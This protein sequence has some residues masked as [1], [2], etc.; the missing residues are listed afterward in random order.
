MLEGTTVYDVD[1]FSVESESEHPQPPSK[2]TH[3]YSRMTRIQMAV[4]IIGTMIFASAIVGAVLLIRGTNKPKPEPGTYPETYQLP[5]RVVAIEPKNEKIGL[6]TLATVISD[7]ISIQLQDVQTDYDNAVTDASSSGFTVH[8]ESTYPIDRSSYYLCQLRRTGY[9]QRLVTMRDDNQIG[10]FNQVQYRIQLNR[11][12]CD[13]TA[14]ADEIREWSVELKIVDNLV[15]RVAIWSPNESGNYLRLSVDIL[16]DQNDEYPM[17]KMTMSWELYIPS[18]GK[19]MEQGTVWT[20]RST[21]NGTYITRAIVMQYINDGAFYEWTFAARV[22]L[23]GGFGS[24]GNGKSSTSRRV[25][26]SECNP[27]IPPGRYNADYQMSW[28][29]TNVYVRQIIVDNN[30]EIQRCYSRDSTTTKVN[31]YG[32]FDPITGDRIQWSTSISLGQWGLEAN[33]I[34]PSP[35]DEN[36]IIVD[37]TEVTRTNG[38]LVSKIINR[39]INDDLD[40]TDDFIYS[41]QTSSDGIVYVIGT[42]GNIMQVSSSDLVVRYDF[43]K[44]IHVG[45]FL[46]GNVYYLIEQ[47]SVEIPTDTVL[48]RPIVDTGC[49]YTK[50]ADHSLL[51]S[52][53][54]P[55]SYHLN[56]P[57]DTDEEGCTIVNM[58]PVNCSS[59]DL[60]IN[61]RHYQWQQ[62]GG[63]NTL[64]RNTTS[65]EYITGFQPRRRIIHNHDTS[66][67]IDSIPEHPN[68]HTYILAWDGLV[69]TMFPVK[70]VSMTDNDHDDNKERWPK[71]AI[72]SGVL[73]NDEEG[74]EYKVVAMNGIQKMGSVSIDVCNQMD[75]NGPS[76]VEKPQSFE[77]RFPLN[78]NKPVPTGLTLV[79]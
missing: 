61:G 39:S 28:E 62:N 79:E 6:K 56:T 29:Q 75:A 17:G 63:R 5:S 16:Q 55:S 77:L 1:L 42:T 48:T 27:V 13:A 65:D 14:T 59:N 4:S 20:D 30:S 58:V 15:G 8:H 45:Y 10:E 74:R 34:N 44:W 40:E 69:L 35:V 3:W 46:T 71:I 66:K 2:P 51:V 60:A 68:G 22:L 52:C 25:I 38:L 26:V 78:H 70:S 41:S 7:G 54:S 49:V 53:E 21:G 73:I 11:A 19:Y 50:Q 18:M 67:S 57:V 32:L 72:K 23:D 47:R 9:Q 43:D 24:G 31:S 64:T 76:G 33:S 37:D 36:P 12:A